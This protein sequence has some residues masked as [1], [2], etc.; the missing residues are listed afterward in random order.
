[1]CIRVKIIFVAPFLANSDA[2]MPSE[3]DWEDYIKD[4]WDY[5][6]AVHL[7]EELQ[8]AIKSHPSFTAPP[9]GPIGDYIVS[10]E[11]H[12][13]IPQ[14]FATSYL[15]HSEEDVSILREVVAAHGESHPAV[16]VYPRCETFQADDENFTIGDRVSLASLRL[17]NPTIA[18]L[19]IDCF[20]TTT[21]ATSTVTYPQLN[22]H[23]CL[24]RSKPMQGRSE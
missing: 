21:G 11:L 12:C 3:Q 8:E 9:M 24:C 7:S 18:N 13:M 19:V 16:M 23:I 15:V 5:E 4:Q 22:L 10:E 14:S 20:G 17:E 1:M 6:H 2:F